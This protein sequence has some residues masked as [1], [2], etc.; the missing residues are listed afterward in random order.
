M[1]LT[2]RLLKLSCIQISPSSVALSS[3]LP[4][5]PGTSRPASCALFRGRLL[6]NK[7]SSS[8]SPSPLLTR[9]LPLLILFC[10]AEATSGA[11]KRRSGEGAF[12]REG[13]SGRALPVWTSHNLAWKPGQSGQRQWGHG[14]LMSILHGHRRSI[15]RDVP[16]PSIAN[17]NR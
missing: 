4:L 2:G 1:S 7:T 13:Y 16:L 8:L 15:M 11:R 6:K 9:T 3:V 12:G 14:E 17:V 5:C 10:A